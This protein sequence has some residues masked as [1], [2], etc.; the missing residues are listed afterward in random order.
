V[1]SVMRPVRE[2]A[3]ILARE[4][5]TVSRVG[6]KHDLKWLAKVRRADLVF[7]LCEGINGIGRWEDLVTATM[8]LAAGPFTGARARTTTIC[9]NKG[10]VNA[11][12]QSAGLPVPRWAVPV[13]GTV[14][15]DFPLPAIVKPA[16]EDASNG[17]EQA[18]VVR[19]RQA[20]RKQVARLS[21]TYGEVI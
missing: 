12:L 6:V 7:N 13:N 8:E 9:H 5:H 2:I 18:S 3:R 1:A 14:P 11:F 19:T 4:G 16:A 10:L 17:I 21:G 20:L 15:D